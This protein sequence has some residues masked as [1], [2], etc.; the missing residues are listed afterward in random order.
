MMVMVMVMVMVA[1]ALYCYP[2]DCKH[3]SGGHPLTPL[4]NAA[5]NNAGISKTH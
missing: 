1:L 5:G 2:Q 3:R 4:P